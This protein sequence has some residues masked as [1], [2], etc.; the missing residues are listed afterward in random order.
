MCIL[1]LYLKII[2]KAL[3]PLLLLFLLAPWFPCNILNS[4]VLVG[5]ER[6]LGICIFVKFLKKLS[7]VSEGGYHLVLLTDM[8]I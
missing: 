3:F 6:D 1:L 5:L 8:R 4:S 7:C 2:W